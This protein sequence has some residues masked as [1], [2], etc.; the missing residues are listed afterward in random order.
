MSKKSKH[1]RNQAK[2][3]ERK[4]EAGLEWLTEW[5]PEGAYQAFRAMAKAA[6]KSHAVPS[7]AHLAE[8][9]ALAAAQQCELP[10]WARG[11][12]VLLSVWMTSTAASLALDQV[13][14]ER[15]AS[16]ARKAEGKAAK[17][18]D[19]AEK[20]DA[21]APGPE[22]EPESEPATASPETAPPTP[23][24]RVRRKPVAAPADATS[25]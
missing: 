12:D 3:M 10:D 1:A 17:A 6:R 21:A 23:V 18:S 7:E 22:P 20:A 8:A 13:Q 2:Y 15:D 11:S 9:L 14:A 24:K 5:V 16:K 25:E 4:R 19:G